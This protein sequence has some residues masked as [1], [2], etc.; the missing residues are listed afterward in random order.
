LA[1]TED[2]SGGA[3][4]L[5]AASVATDVA[6]S[7][8]GT[9]TADRLIEDNTVDQHQVFQSATY[10]ANV[11]IAL[12]FYAKAET[13]SWVGIE[14]ADDFE[15]TQAWFDIG[16]GVV[17]SHSSSTWVLISKTVSNEGGGWYR[18]QIVW[19]T[20]TSNTNLFLSLATSTADGILSYFGDGTSSILLWGLQV[21]DA[22]SVVGCYDANP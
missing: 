7:P 3:W 6:N 14:F 21:E 9:L 12:S 20:N 2:L 22:V 19:A 8:I 11:T 16:T 5:G 15:N 18:C 1:N 13:R 4:S 17:G 10:S